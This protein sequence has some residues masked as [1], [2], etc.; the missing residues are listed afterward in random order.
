MILGALTLPA[1]REAK[2]QQAEREV[3]LTTLPVSQGAL[4]IPGLIAI[5]NAGTL[6]VGFLD[7]GF[8]TIPDYTAFNPRGLDR[9]YNVQFSLG[10]FSRVVISG[11]GSEVRPSG[12]LPP[13]FFRADGGRI[14]LLESS[15]LSRDLSASVHLLVLKEGAVWPAIAVG[16][17]DFGGSASQLEARYAV[18]SKTLAG[19]L[20]LTA[21]Y[22]WG[23]D[24]LKGG[25]GGIEVA[26]IPQVTLLGEYDADRFN[27]GLRLQP[28][29]SGLVSR[30]VPQATLDV[31]W[32]EGEGVTWGVAL[33]AVL[34]QD[35]I[36]RDPT[37]IGD[38]QESGSASSGGGVG[39][40]EV[41]ARLLIEDGFENVDISVREGA[42]LRVEYENR[43][44]NQHELDGLARVLRVLSS[45]LPDGIDNLRIVL[46]QTGLRALQIDLGAGDL[47]QFLGGMIGSDAF[48]DRVTIGY[49]NASSPLMGAVSRSR[50][51]SFFK[52]DLTLYPG[53]E[54]VAFSEIGVAEAR[55]TF[56]PNLRVALFRGTVLEAQYRVPIGQTENFYR[57]LNGPTDTELDRVLLHHTQWWSLS[58]RAALTTQWSVGR[59]DVGN[60]GI[61][62]EASLSML[63]GLVR[64]G[65]D[66]AVLGDD[67]H[68][69][70]RVVALGSARLLI[71]AVNTRI[72]VT[73]GQYLDQDHGVTADVSRFFA[74]TEIGIFLRHSGRGSL[75]G[76]RIALPLTFGKDL[77][78]KYLRVRTPSEWRHQQRSVVFD[79]T[80]EIR[81]DIARILPARY[82][83]D[84]SYFDRD[85][86][87][88][89][90]VE[91]ALARSRFWR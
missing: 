70:D 52:S 48:V 84:Q 26:P 91:A 19:R 47:R 32:A 74:D 75:A 57:S 85:R 83:L 53:L 71:P 76:L 42:L 41:L 87:N 59:F 29:P 79:E 38:G 68:K 20:R 14:V 1:A 21:G 11:R 69:L 33:R 28:V 31:T 37:L 43:R 3:G 73:A 9:Q 82:G 18:A 51:S 30:G 63:G 27:G 23:E 66:V 54:T 10:L 90:A 5:P 50:N 6:P 55:L 13:R 89:V 7:L 49:S 67:R 44:Y 88:P 80:N 35:W 2:G 12:I 24:L 61:R 58:D 72:K 65:A 81:S 40:V 62:Q 4:G 17:R 16:A 60:V 45:N 34:D 22:G 36:G 86:L 77:P 56:L 8:N 64:L 39:A 25:F 78:P 46:K 15:F